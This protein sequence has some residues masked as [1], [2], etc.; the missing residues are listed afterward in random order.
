MDFNERRDNGMVYKSD[1]S[2]YEQ[3]KIARRLTH[4][5]NTMD[6]SDFD[7]IEK[8]VRPDMKSMT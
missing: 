3:E 5:I 7:G 4:E 6:T 1:K 2:V 8:K